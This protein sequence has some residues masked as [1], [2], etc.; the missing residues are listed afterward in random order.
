ML[1]LCEVSDGVCY[2]QSRTQSPE[3]KRKNAVDRRDKMSREN[4]EPTSSLDAQKRTLN[5]RLEAVG[6]GLFFIMIGGLWLVPGEVLP[7]GTWL[8]GVGVIMLGLNLARYMNGIKMSWFTIVL[9]VLALAAGLG[10]Y[11]GVELPLIPIVIVLVGLSIIVGV[12]TRED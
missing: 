4:T 11:V 9:G 8:I 5:K 3:Y 2:D 7:E 12:L 1:F 10:D 6:W